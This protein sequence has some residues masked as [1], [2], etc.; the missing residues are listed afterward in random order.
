MRLMQT[1]FMF[2]MV[3]LV[4]CAPESRE[5]VL[6]LNEP[7]TPKSEGDRI[8]IIRSD[9]TK[10]EITDLCA[11]KIGSARM[12]FTNMIANAE[13]APENF[14]STVLTYETVW[15]DLADAVYPLTFMGY[16]STDAELRDEGFAC[17]EALS[18]FGVEMAA[19]KDVYNALRNAIP[20][21]SEEMRLKSETLLGFEKNGLNLPDQDL[22]KVTELRQLLSKTES[23]FSQNLNED[24]STVTFTKDDLEGVPEYIVKRFKTDA[25]GNF[26]VTTKSTDYVG[27]AENAKKPATRKA[28]L[29]AYLN[30]AGAANTKLLETA[31]VLREQIAAALGYKTWA[32]YRT[33]GRMAETGDTVLNFLNSLKGKL[34]QRNADDIQILLEAKK[35]EEPGATAIEPW[36]IGYYTNQVKKS[37][38]NLDDE[39]ISQYFPKDTVMKGL[40]KVY[41]TL[42]NVNFEEVV[43]ADV[44]HPD[45]KM[46]AIREKSDNSIIAYFYT[47]LF[48]REGKY[49]HAAAFPLI[50]GRMIGSGYSQPV[51]SIVAN[52]TPPTADTPSLLTH[53]EVETMFHEFGHIMHQTLTRAPYASLSG[54]STAQDFV[55]APSQM[56]ENWVW[57]K[58][59][60]TIVS[61]HKD[62]GEPLPDSILS[63]MLAARNFNQGYFYTRQLVL[64]L[65]DMTIHTQSG[66]VS[67]DATYDQVYQEL[68]GVKPLENA[69][70]MATFGHMMGGYDAGYY[71]Y[72]WSEVYAADMFT[73]F[74][75]NLL[76]E[77]VG[78]RYRHEILE[79]GHMLPEIQIVENFIGR[80]PTNDAFYKKLGIQ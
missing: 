26:I 24:V 76:D 46:Y 20:R 54:S 32:D 45:V 7:L 44:W 9:Y 39:L 53:D 68:L 13:A 50:S 28:I 31:V 23:E 78:L 18:S 58:Q 43:N 64:G 41:S 34:A 55:E 63:Q 42:L 62:T 75:G 17:E 59:I 67:V 6:G 70:F 14:H 29:S 51:A 36:D 22:A 52:F 30:R 35:L 79:K 1:V 4:G 8:T 12:A 56:L 73:A 74:S 38:F 3:V 10:G 57:N 69:H 40:F 33:D 19:R 49:G 21:N 5:K 16:T 72:I 61:G 27:V 25:T 66:P 60:L 77:N 48:P 71:G 65:T 15:A 2:L 80:K 11:A 37:K 47:D